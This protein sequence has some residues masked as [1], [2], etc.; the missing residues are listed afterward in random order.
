[1]PDLLIS[2]PGESEHA[3]YFSRYIDL[4]PDGDILGTLAGQI[5]VTLAELR[6]ISERNSL[7][8]YQSG[9]WS[10]REVVGHEHIAPGRKFDPGAGFDWARLIAIGSLPSACFPAET[11]P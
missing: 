6:K 10:V 4:V 5:G 1:M 9:K 2:K 7:L 11:L 3:P 8:R